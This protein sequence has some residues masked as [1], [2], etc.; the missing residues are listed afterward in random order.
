MEIEDENGKRKILTIE[1]APRE[2]VIRQVRGRRNRL[3]TPKERDLLG[4]WADQEGL[5][6]AGYI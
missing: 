6:L 4:K 2:K 1:V 3:A 5:Q